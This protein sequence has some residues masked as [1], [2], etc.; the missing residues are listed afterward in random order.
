[1]VPNLTVWITPF[2]GVTSLDEAIGRVEALSLSAGAVPN[3]LLPTHFGQWP[4]AECK[5][6]LP[7]DLLV[8]GPTDVAPIRQRVEAAGIGFGCWGV[9]V[10]LTS[11][12]L[13][14]G[15]A[16]AGGYYVANFEPDQFWTPGDDPAAVDEWWSRYWN[17]LPAPDALSGNTAATVVPNA[18]GLDA[19]K[20]SLPNLAAGCGALCLEVYGGLQTQATYP[21]P[22]LWPTN[23]FTQV[24]AIGV[25]ANLIPIVAKANLPSQKTLAA[26]LGNGNI[27]VWCL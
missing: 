12:E 27:H 19:F 16:D 7:P 5:Q 22:N 13:A 3:L 2:T 1:M 21:R 9:P 8:A 23:G 18:W 26:H 15:F 10:D 6:T 14:A 20:N 11:P 4:Q 25:E 24:R 17:A